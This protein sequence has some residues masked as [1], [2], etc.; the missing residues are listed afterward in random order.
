LNK[1]FGI[2]NIECINYFPF[3]RPYDEYRELLEYDVQEKRKVIDTIFHAIKTLKIE[4]NF[5]KF[6]RDFF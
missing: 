6:P 3:D 1:K 2:R 5:V 4:A